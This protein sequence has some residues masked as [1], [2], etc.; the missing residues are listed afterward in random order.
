MT[1][2]DF[3]H[4]FLW[5]AATSAYQVEGGND[6]SDWWDWEQ[7][8]GTPCAAPSGEACE[9]YTRYP[10]DIALLAS[11]GLNT[12]RFSV[13][14]SRVEPADGTFDLKALAHYARVVECV[15]EN[16]LVPMVTLNHFTLPRW[17]AA[18]GGW[19]S[20]RTPALFDRYC[21]QVIQALG[22]GVPWYCTIN[23]P[24]AMSTGGYMNDW[25]FPPGVVD[26]R[27]WRTSI[28]LLIDAH[29]RAVASIHELRPGAR[30]GLAAFT[31]ERKTNAGG[32]PAVAYATRMNEDVFLEATDEDDFIG[33]QTYTR[34]HLFLPRIAAPLTRLALAVRPIENLLAPRLLGMKTAAPGTQALPG[35]RV[36]QMG[37]EYRPEALGAVVR[38][39]AKL[40]PGKDLVVTENGV[41]TAD[42][43]ERVEFIRRALAALH[44]AM[45]DGARVRGYVHWS[46]MDNFEWAHGYGPKFGLVA[47]DWKTQER[48]PR[49]S[50]FYLGGIAK[51]GRL[52]VEAEPAAEGPAT[53]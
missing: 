45:D 25:G 13:E 4:D 50:A 6:N 42:D 5:G 29:R 35:Q 46:L 19:T 1:T 2:L 53:A 38:R 34:T 15:L 12:Y 18:E 33:V 41:A 24:T 22:D 51:T 10:S 28:S 20:K 9:H 52:E 8:P 30:A 43:A 16:G 7:A 39:I 27:K 36:T 21:R 40:C 11:L 44:E 3:P 14:W 23:E 49:P 37:W 48:A 26:V 31:G 47:V 17:V 32:R